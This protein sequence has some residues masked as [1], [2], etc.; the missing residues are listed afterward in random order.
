[1]DG[2]RFYKMNGAGNQI[3]ML[4]L[5]DQP[6]VVTPD[7]ARAIANYEG[8]FFDQLMVLTEPRNI[9]TA[10]FVEIW[11]NDGTRAGACGNGTRCIAAMELNRLDAMSVAFE[12]EAGLLETVR[13]GDEITVDMGEPKFNWFDIPLAWDAGDTKAIDLTYSKHGVQLSNPSVVSMGNPHVIFWVADAELLDLAA[14]GPELEHHEM[15]PERANI[16]L[17]QVTSRDNILLKVWERGAGQTLACGSAA[18]AVAVAA[19]RLSKTGRE[20]TV[21]LPG[22]DLKMHWRDDNHV[23][24]TGPWELEHEGILPAAMFAQSDAA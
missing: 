7:V 19:A 3:V 5:R 13:A 20:V 16:S 17:A 9:N 6:G 22:G 24:M 1:M 11:N 4:D 21:S 2:K 15:F 14:I 8:A 12:T 10:A 18:C 23:L